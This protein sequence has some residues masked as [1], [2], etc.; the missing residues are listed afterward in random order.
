MREA[1]GQDDDVGA[2]EARLLVPDE[3]RLLP[4]HVLGGVIGVVIAVGTG[5]D[6]DAEFHSL[7]SYF[8]CGPASAS[9]RELAVIT[10]CSLTADGCSYSIST[11]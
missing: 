3:L 8:Q 9:L 5:K 2:L 6:D 4:E 7:P 11:R 1:A 10:S